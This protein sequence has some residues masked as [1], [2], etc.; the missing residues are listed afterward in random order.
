MGTET[1][2]NLALA[3]VGPSPVVLPA[4]RTDEVSPQQLIAVWCEAQ[5]I[6]WEDGQ[7]RE[8]T[9]RTVMEASRATARRLKRPLAIWTDS[10]EWD[11]SATPATQYGDQWWLRCTRRPDET[12]PA[13][14]TRYDAGLEFCPLAHAVLVVGLDGP[15]ET[16]EDALEHLVLCAELARRHGDVVGM[17]WV[18]TQSTDLL[19]RVAANLE[20]PGPPP[21]TDIEP[22]AWGQSPTP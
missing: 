14:V 10:A 18:G 2:I 11:L 9:L 3:G 16:D 12:I 17:V 8:H 5:P 4:D 20:L 13:A 22:L 6:T 19:L 21:I 7:P 1:L 15:G